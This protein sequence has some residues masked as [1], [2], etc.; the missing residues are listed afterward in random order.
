MDTENEVAQSRS[1][2]KSAVTVIVAVRNDAENLERCLE[3]VAQSLVAPQAIIVV[4]DGSRDNSAAVATKHLA[5]LVILPSSQGS[6]AARNA[7]VAALRRL[8]GVAT[9]RD[10]IFFLDSDIRIRPDTISR[11]LDGLTLRPDA[12]AIVGLYDDEPLNRRLVSR[13]R[14]LLIHDTQ[15]A[16]PREPAMFFTGCGLIRR[17]HFEALGDFQPGNVAEDVDFA[18]RLREADRLVLLQPDAFVTHMKCFTLRKTISTDLVLRGVP[19]ATLVLSG[20]NVFGFGRTTKAQLASTAAAGCLVLG[21]LWAVGAAPLVAAW[22]VLCYVALAGLDALPDST[23][24][25]ART[26]VNISAL[27]LGVVGSAA[28]LM[29]PYLPGL[30]LLGTAGIIISASRRFYTLLIRKSGVAFTFFAFFAHLLY[31]G[32]GLSAMLIAALRLAFNCDQ[33]I[34]ESPSQDPV[35]TK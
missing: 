14:N 3:A 18:L 12:V 15:V 10:F 20:R 19:W 6:A 1:V 35:P 24:A 22:F 9:P 7:G 23:T 5:D 17:E 28:M 11:L 30:L 32:C 34:A 8:H 29:S 4:D 16:S 21:W 13:Y 31:F 33:K 26:L 2:T 27:A 25:S